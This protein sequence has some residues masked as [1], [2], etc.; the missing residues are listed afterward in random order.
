MQPI[1]DVGEFVVKAHEVSVVNHE[2]C[3]DLAELGLDVFLCPALLLC[4]VR[5]GKLLA[6]PLKLL[7]AVP[8][9]LVQPLVLLVLLLVL[10]APL[11]RIL[12]ARDAHGG[13][14]HKLHASTHYPPLVVRVQLA[15]LHVQV[16]HCGGKEAIQLCVLVPGCDASTQPLGEFRHFALALELLF[17]HVSQRQPVDYARLELVLRH[18]FRHF[19][20]P[21]FWRLVLRFVLSD[22]LTRPRPFPG[23]VNSFRFRIV[24]DV[25]PIV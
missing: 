9:L 23:P 12:L 11:Q 21:L 22:D 14:R 8:Q 19:V 18:P 25:R 15:R 6:Q 7:L 20:R 17:V 24:L 1:L 10:T 5:A 13:G 3:L 4:A 16:P 2:L